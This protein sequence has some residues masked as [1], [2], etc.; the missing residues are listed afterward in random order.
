MVE[1]LKIDTPFNRDVDGSKK[2]IEGSWKDD[3]LEYLADNTWVWTEKVDGTNIGVVW[4]GHKVSFQGRT[5]RAD[6]PKPLLEKL[7]EMFGSLEVE[8][9]FEQKFG[10]KTVILFGEG[11]GPKIQ[12]GGNYRPDVSFILFDVYIPEN[13]LY[14]KRDA[15]EDIAKCFDIDIVPIVGTGTLYEAIDYVKTKPVSEVSKLYVVKSDYVMEG[16]VC[17][18][19]V[20]LR[21]RMGKR[22]I[23]KVK[24]KDFE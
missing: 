24:V 7:N 4:D 8:E 22:V 12:S 1:Y 23:V 13:D 3:T 18:P 19:L 9:L 15:V 14:L 21:N 16:V 20:E 17:R 5:E 11:Y 2:L 10:E 6:I